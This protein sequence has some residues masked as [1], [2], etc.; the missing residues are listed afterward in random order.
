MR[1]KKLNRPL[2]VS[3]SKDFARDLTAL[4][5]KNP[6]VLVSPKYINGNTLFAK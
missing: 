2:K 5:K 6:D 3:Y 1:N 4:A